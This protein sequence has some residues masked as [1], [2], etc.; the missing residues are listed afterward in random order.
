[1]GTSD[2]PGNQGLYDQLLALEWIY[3]NIKNFG[4]DPQ[5]ITLFGESA[6]AVSI[7]L[8]IL[9]PKSRH[10]FNNAILQSSG[11]TGK[12]AVLTP[13]VAKYR[14]EKFLNV[15]TRYITDHYQAGPTDP[16]YASIP[17]QCRKQMITIE[18][19]FLCVK[20]YPILNHTHFRSSWALESYNGGPIGY[21]FVPTIDSDFIPY[22]PEQMLIKGDYKRCPILLGVNQDEGAYFNVYVPYGNMSIDSWAY[23]DYKTFQQAIKEYFRY[24]PIYPTESTPIVLESILQTYTLWND[25]NNTVQNA[26]QLSFAVGKKIYIKLLWN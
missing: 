3:K 17:Q 15:L 11:P 13:Q 9:S 7:G 20:N 18:D 1:L 6:G 16:E 26:L 14:S 2:A 12:W 4:G 25:S 8:H 5:R 10:L 19:K 22:D 23:V 24:I 21:T